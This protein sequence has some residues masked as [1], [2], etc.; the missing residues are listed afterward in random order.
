MVYI[1]YTTINIT[2][3]KTNISTD[4][5]HCVKSVVMSSTVTDASSQTYAPFINCS[6]LTDC[7]MQV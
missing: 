5:V 4:A 1:H 7:C 2:V 6:L 3:S